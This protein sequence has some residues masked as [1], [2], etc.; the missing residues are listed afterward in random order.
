MREQNGDDVLLKVN[1]DARHQVQE[2]FFLF[3]DRCLNSIVQ[4]VLWIFFVSF[5]LIIKFRILLVRIFDQL[6]VK[7]CD[8]TAE[9]CLVVGGS[10]ELAANAVRLRLEGG[11]LLAASGEHLHLDFCLLGV[12]NIKLSHL[13]VEDNQFLSV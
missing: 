8:N 9:K 4:L 1:I 11:V 13:L 7:V 6:Q 2:V 3:F 10:V 5:I 12:G